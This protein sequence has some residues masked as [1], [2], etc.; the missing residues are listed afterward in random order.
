VATTWTLLTQLGTV[1]VS[2][3]PVGLKVHVVMPAAVVQLPAARAG[4]ASPSAIR[5]AARAAR[6]AHLLKPIR[7]FNVVAIFF[8]FPRAL[9][10]RAVK[11][12]YGATGGSADR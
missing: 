6:I 1:K 12:N 5:L 7:S 8:S 11:E 3:A 4:L 9:S 10:G 2:S